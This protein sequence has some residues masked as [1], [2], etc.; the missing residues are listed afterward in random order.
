[1]K[2]NPFAGNLAGAQYLKPQP[3]PPIVE[4]LSRQIFNAGPDC[5][6]EMAVTIAKQFVRDHSD[7][8]LA[9]H[10]HELYFVTLAHELFRDRLQDLEWT[11]T[12]V[13]DGHPPF[14]WGQLATGSDDIEFHVDF[15]IKGPNGEEH[16]MEL[17]NGVWMNPFEISGFTAPTS[18]E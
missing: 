18:D 16:S 3:L 1:M 11:V 14:G 17:T 12:L 15:E 5:T 8:S 2:P 9:Q 10:I 13:E 7:F 4:Q 6:P